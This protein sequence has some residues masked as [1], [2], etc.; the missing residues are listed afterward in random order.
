MTTGARVRVHPTGRPSD[1]AIGA[2]LLISANGRSIAIA[3]EHLPPFAF[4]NDAPFAV[5]GCGAVLLATRE[6]SGPMG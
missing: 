4:R 3:F 1:A 6:R 2:V 5:A